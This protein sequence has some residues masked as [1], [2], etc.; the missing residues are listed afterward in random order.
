M[1]YKLGTTRILTNQRGIPKNAATD[2]IQDWLWSFEPL[3]VVK[4]P[5]F[6]ILRPYTYDERLPFP[7]LLGDVRV[8]ILANTR[9]RR[10]FSPVCNEL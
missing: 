3:H 2:S 6:T 10:E 7:L 4:T 1:D 8:R 5:R 9:Q